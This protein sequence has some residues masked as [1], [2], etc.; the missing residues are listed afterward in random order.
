VQWVAG[1]EASLLRH[2]AA[3]SSAQQQQLGGTGGF[4]AAAGA[5][6][7]VLALLLHP[8]PRAQLAAGA[9]LAAAARANGLLGVSSIPALA[10]AVQRSVEGFCSGECGVVGVGWGG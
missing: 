7:V 4:G 10:A 6:P 5:L 2:A 1:V 3:T 8:A 9:A